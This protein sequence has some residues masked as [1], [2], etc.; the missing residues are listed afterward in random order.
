MDVLAYGFSL[1]GHRMDLIELDGNRLD[2]DDV[3]TLKF[4]TLTAPTSGT[5]CDV[6][7]CSGASSTGTFVSKRTGS[8]SRA[9]AKAAIRITGA[10][11]KNENCC[12]PL[13]DPTCN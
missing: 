3:G 5:N 4:P 10:R 2:D 8:T 9:S 13:E 12:D 7:D 1:S 11:F 6:Y